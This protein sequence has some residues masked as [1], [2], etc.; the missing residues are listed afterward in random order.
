MTGANFMSASTPPKANPE[1][2]LSNSEAEELLTLYQKQWNTGDLDEYLNG[3][4]EDVVVEFADQPRI[5]GKSALREFI[6]ARTVRQ[7]GYQLHKTLRDV[8]GS[9]IVCSFVAS[10]TDGKTGK[11]MRGRGIEFIQIQQRKCV[12]W[13]AAFNAWPE[14]EPRNSFLT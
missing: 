14:N 10:W 8:V 7:Q 12:Y 4:T 6:R 5:E 9:T 3:F 13:E 2:G 1:E 11:P